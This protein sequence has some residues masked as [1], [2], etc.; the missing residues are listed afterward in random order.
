MAMLRDVNESRAANVEDPKPEELEFRGLTKATRI[1][2]P[3][4][5]LDLLTSAVPV[6]LE[7]LANSL[8]QLRRRNEES[9]VSRL[10]LA[11]LLIAR[12]HQ[13]IKRLSTARGAK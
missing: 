3:T 1:D 9:L 4:R 10:H 11:A 7:D 2:I 8:R 5:D 13:A 12:C 6:E